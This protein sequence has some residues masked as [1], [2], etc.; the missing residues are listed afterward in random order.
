MDIQFPANVEKEIR[1][2]AEFERIAPEEAA[3]KLVEDALRT[4]HSEGIAMDRSEK[5]GLTQEQW[6]ELRADPV[7]AFFLDMPDEVAANIEQASR[8]NRAEILK[9]RG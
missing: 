8:E 5:G 2:Y 1:A 6:D 9:P 4:K 7:I 3:V